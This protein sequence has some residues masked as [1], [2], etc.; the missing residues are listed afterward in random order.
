VALPPR[1]WRGLRRAAIAAVVSS[2]NAAERGELKIQ[3]QPHDKGY[4]RITLPTH[5]PY[6]RSRTNLLHRHLVERQIGRRLD[7]FEHVHHRPGYPKDTRE[8]AGLEVL[9]EC[10][11]GHYH[12]GERRG[13]GPELELWS[14]KGAS[15]AEL[16]DQGFE[17]RRATFG[18]P[19]EAA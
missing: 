7:R 3:P 1:W 14:G 10:A 17:E 12:Y 9:E 2:E 16:S 4:V 18:P 13:C 8:L 11:H 15:L 5:H 19:S 6:A